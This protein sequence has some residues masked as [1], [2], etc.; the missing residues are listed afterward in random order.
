MMRCSRQPPSGV[1][2]KGVSHNGDAPHSRSGGNP[3]TSSDV[4]NFN[5]NINLDNVL[6]N[7]YSDGVQFSQAKGGEGREGSMPPTGGHILVV[8]AQSTCKIGGTRT[9]LGGVL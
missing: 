1:T 6:D 4:R 7:N 3:N 9:E 5:R 8:H 2:R